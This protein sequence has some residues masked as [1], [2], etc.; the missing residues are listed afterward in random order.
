M[1][2]GE[3]LPY[4]TEMILIAMCVIVLTL[5]VQGMSLSPIVRALH[6]EPEQAHHAE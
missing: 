4:R 6:F 5:L 1:A 2:S 3:P